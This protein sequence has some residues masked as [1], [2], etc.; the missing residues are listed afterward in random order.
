MVV[1]TIHSDKLTDALYSDLAKR[2]NNE[3]CEGYAQTHWCACDPPPAPPP[4][5]PQP[6]PAPVAGAHTPTPNA[7]A[8]PGT[9]TPSR[10]GGTLE[11][12]QSKLTNWLAKPKP[13][14][15]PAVKRVP[16]PGCGGTITVYAVTDYSH[17]LAG[18]GLVGQKITVQVE[19]PGRDLKQ[20]LKW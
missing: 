13:K 2:E 9:P 11:R 17:A 12:S 4:P 5:T 3:S 10:P 20:A 1:H 16:P 6:T 18:Q 15:R 7:V 8:E 14:P 19:H